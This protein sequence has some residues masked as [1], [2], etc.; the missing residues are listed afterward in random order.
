MPHHDRYG[1]KERRLP[2][3]EASA[4]ML[5]LMDLTKTLGHDSPLSALR[6]L[7]AARKEL[8]YLRQRVKELQP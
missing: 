8:T 4:G 5:E 2:Q 1:R 3:I 7:I 6:E